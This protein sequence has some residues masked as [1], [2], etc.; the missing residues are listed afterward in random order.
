MLTR[1][2]CQTYE[3]QKYEWKSAAP[4]QHHIAPPLRVIPAK[5]A[6][7]VWIPAYAGMT[8]KAAW[9]KVKH[10]AQLSQNI[11]LCHHYD[12]SFTLYP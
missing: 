12:L 7:Q 3:I 2:R 4:A 9:Q 1:S 11:P 8:L 5:A 10:E 6:I